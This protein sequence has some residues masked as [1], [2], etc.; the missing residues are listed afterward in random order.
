MSELV[1]AQGLGTCDESVI[2]LAALGELA[3]KTAEQHA[4]QTA[5]F[6][7]ERAAAARLFEAVIA[8]IRPGLRAI[9]Y[10]PKV[11]SCTRWV[12][13][14]A[15]DTTEE[16]ADWAGVCL[17]RDKPGPAFDHPSANR[18]SF[19]GSALFLR[20]D[21]SLVRLTYSGSWS[22][23]QGEGDEWTADEK[24]LTPLEAVKAY[25]AEDLPEWVARLTRRC[26]EQ[27]EGKQAVKTKAALERA[28]KL[29][30]LAR[31]SAIP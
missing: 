22:K 30:A 12:S 20:V 23:W 13:S 27:L 11:S 6:E 28:A 18:G 15:T 21:G 4:E 5:A 29:E 8:T 31:L 7:A 19:E 25:G 24:R 14:V 3:T 17:D 10:R 2:D 26:R 16:R 9:S 1:P